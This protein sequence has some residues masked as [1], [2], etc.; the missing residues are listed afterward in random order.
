MFNLSKH[1][2]FINHFFYL[3]KIIQFFK[4]WS[5]GANRLERVP[6]RFNVEKSEQTEN[7]P[8]TNRF[9]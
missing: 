8:V 7:K 4:G 9:V 1:Y 5:T 2:F 3:F 6:I